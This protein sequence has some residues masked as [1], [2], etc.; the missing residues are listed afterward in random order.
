MNKVNLLGV[1]IDD[2]NINEAKTTILKW[3]SE[4]G[5]H[6]IVTPNPE[7]LVIAQTD[8][9]F[10]NILNS[11]DLAIPDGAGLKFSQKIKNTLPGVDLM[12]VLIQDCAD[13]G[14]TV[15]L[16]GGSK[17]LANKLAERLKERY[18]NLKIEIADS[19]FI[20]NTRGEETIDSTLN[21]KT[22]KK[23]KKIYHKDLYKKMDILFV[24]F[25]HI[26]QEKWITKNI[27]K[28]N[29]KVMMGVGGAFDYL[30]GNIPR[31]PKWLRILGMEWLFRLIIQPRRIKRQISLI[32]Y[33]WLLATT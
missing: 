12:E 9:E 28:L 33:L 10:K 19:N 26:K 15:G 11:A 14:F 29:I 21:L 4:P 31:A 24:A 27:D 22:D 3:L 2:L 13:K 1:K 6:Y 16:I 5:K 18:K 23:D 32:K 7:F 17:N 20:V 30:S 25:G 8:A